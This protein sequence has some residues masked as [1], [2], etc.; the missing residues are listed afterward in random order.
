M[1]V[2]LCLAAGLAV[3]LTACANER[4][5]LAEFDGGPYRL[6]AAG[7]VGANGVMPEKTV[8]DK[9]LTAMALE[10]VTGLKPDP[11]RFLDSN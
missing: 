9:I 1:L 11:G 7:I 5:G 8:S 6:G 2:R 4:P 3:A 10:R